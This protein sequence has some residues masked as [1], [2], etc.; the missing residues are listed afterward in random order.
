MTKYFTTTH[1]SYI[2]FPN[3]F[4]FFSRSSLTSSPFISPH[5]HCHS[6]RVTTSPHTSKHNS[7]LSH[8]EDPCLE[9]HF[10]L[11]FPT[12]GVLALGLGGTCGPYLQSEC[13]R[14]IT[15]SR[16]PDPIAKLGRGGFFIAPQDTLGQEEVSSRGRC[17]VTEES[18][19]LPAGVEG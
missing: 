18:T 1:Y 16:N 2:H 15:S 13:R 3:I 10:S 8:R 19:L 11:A 7:V 17:N 4:F 9:S 5:G 6:H 12:P 14:R